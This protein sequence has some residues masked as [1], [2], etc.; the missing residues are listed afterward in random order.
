MNRRM[1][2]LIA[3]A[4]V[5]SVTCEGT[6]QEDGKSAITVSFSPSSAVA[7][8]N[9]WIVT[10]SWDGAVAQVKLFRVFTKFSID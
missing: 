6:V 2:V 10:G 5:S 4:R 9:H 1:S 3:Q 7:D 8:V